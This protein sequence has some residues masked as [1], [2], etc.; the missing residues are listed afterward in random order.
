[1]KTLKRSKAFEVRLYMGSRKDS[2]EDIVRWAGELAAVLMSR[3]HQEQMTAVIRDE[4]V[5]FSQQ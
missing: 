2:D 5:V 1:M 3:F 4:L